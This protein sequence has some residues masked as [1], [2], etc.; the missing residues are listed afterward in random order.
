[1]DR[2]RSR[3]RRF[4]QGDA[5]Q[6]R[7]ITCLEGLGCIVTRTGQEHLLTDKMH[8]VLRRMHTDDTAQFARF[9]PDTLAVLPGELPPC[10]YEVKSTSGTH[11]GKNGKNFSI[12]LAALTVYQVLECNG[13]RVIVA[14][15][16]VPG[17][18]FYIARA[19]TI[20]PFREIGLG[21]SRGGSGTPLGLVRKAGFPQLSIFTLHLLL[22]E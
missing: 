16:D 9:A 15:E 7:L 6:D 11:Q 19:K 10:Y 13:V 17:N 4:R 22:E 2:N 8:A 14:F 21:Q 12:E 3:E 18:G 20:T 1:M 5:A